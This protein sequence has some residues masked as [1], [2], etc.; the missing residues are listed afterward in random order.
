MFSIFSVHGQLIFWN[1]SSEFTEN[2]QG[3][4]LFGINDKAQ[5]KFTEPTFQK[6]LFSSPI[7]SPPKPSQKMLPLPRL[8]VLATTCLSLCYSL[9]CYQ[10]QKC[11]P[12]HLDGK[13]PVCSTH[14]LCHPLCMQPFGHCRVYVSGMNAPI[15]KPCGWQMDFHSKPVN[16]LCCLGLE[17]NVREWDRLME[18]KSQ[19]KV[20][21]TIL[22][23]FTI[24]MWNDF[25]LHKPGI[26]YTKTFKLGLWRHDN[27]P[28]ID[29]LPWYLRW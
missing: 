16:L 29:G 15:L 14:I 24:L 13:L 28:E 21:V 9:L 27:K 10:L 5:L 4:K 17:Y 6:Q 11:L 1:R 19:I 25:Y 23:I 7:L 22:D 12:S 2:W 18:T 8:L 26:I 20:S 3:V